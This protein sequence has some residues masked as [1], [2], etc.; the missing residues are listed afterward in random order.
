MTANKNIILH[1]GSCR[2]VALFIRK[3]P[4]EGIREK[5]IGGDTRCVYE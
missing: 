3:E 5:W 4:R 1:R 2:E